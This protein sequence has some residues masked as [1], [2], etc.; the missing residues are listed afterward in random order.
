MKTIEPLNATIFAF[1]NEAK[2]DKAK[3][4][5]RK[6]KKRALQRPHRIVCCSENNS[7][8]S[9]IARSLV[10]TIRPVVNLPDARG[11]AALPSLLGAFS[12]SSLDLYL[13]FFLEL[14]SNLTKGFGFLPLLLYNCHSK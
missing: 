6:D 9:K 8:R 2:Q 5:E 10:H 7:D 14:F 11:S 12:I 13:E 3:C 4:E 1:A